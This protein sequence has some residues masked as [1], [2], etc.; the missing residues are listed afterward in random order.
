MK[1]MSMFAWKQE[2]S[3]GY[4]EI[5]NQHKKLFELAEQLYE[6][7]AGG[8]G[9]NV[10]AKTLGNLIAYTKGHFANEE[11]L[12]QLHHY[13]DYAKHKADHDALTARVVGFQK[14]FEA[15]RTALSIGLLQF[16]KDWLSHHI[17]ETDRKIA[18][19]LKSKAA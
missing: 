2:Y 13:P 12:M 17:G 15:H 10:L 1:Y 4:P 6:A 5:D 11:R 7:M 9:N 18:A 19:Y 14:E 8:K 16:L 3:V